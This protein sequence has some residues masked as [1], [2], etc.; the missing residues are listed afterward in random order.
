MKNYK[1]EIERILSKD[2]PL[3]EDLSILLKHGDWV[4]FDIE[5]LKPKNKTVTLRMNDELLGAL[6]KIAKKEGIDYQKF[7]RLTLEKEVKKRGA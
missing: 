6:K 1:K 3:E 7:I 4:P 5:M 2:D